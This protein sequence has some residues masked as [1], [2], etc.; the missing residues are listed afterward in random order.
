M[1]RSLMIDRNVRKVSLIPIAWICI[2]GLTVGGR[3]ISVSNVER[4]SQNMI[5]LMHT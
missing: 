4:V 3:V 2:S 5:V 1:G